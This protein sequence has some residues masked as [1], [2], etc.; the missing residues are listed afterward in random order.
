MRGLRYSMWIAVIVIV[1]AL[2]YLKK[3]G[4]PITLPLSSV[5]IAALAVTIGFGMIIEQRYKH[6]QR[7]PECG[8]FMREVYEDFHP[9]AKH[10]HILYCECC[11]IIW[12][13]TIPKYRR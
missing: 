2:T 8:K 7:C 6:H 4:E 11:D 5:L 3:F 10:Y 12:D 1:A 9:S 13:T